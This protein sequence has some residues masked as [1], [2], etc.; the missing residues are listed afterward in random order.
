MGHAKKKFGTFFTPKSRGGEV[1]TP[2]PL[3]AP[4][5]PSPSSPLCVA[6]PLCVFGPALRS[7]SFSH[8]DRATVQGGSP[9]PLDWTFRP[10]PLPLCRSGLGVSDWFSKKKCD[11]LVLGS[12]NDPPGGGGSAKKFVI[13]SHQLAEGKSIWFLSRKWEVTLP[14]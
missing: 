11:W 2:T 7:S 8:P 14:Q 5:S 4:L 12:G 3:V 9:H 10:P 1:S 6:N 13:R